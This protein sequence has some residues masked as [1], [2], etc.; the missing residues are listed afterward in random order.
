MLFIYLCKGDLYSDL[1]KGDLY[2]RPAGFPKQY[3]VLQMSHQCQV[4]WAVRSALPIPEL[5]QLSIS[6]VQAVPSGPAYW[7]VSSVGPAVTSMPR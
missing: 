5:S 2:F 7:V 1:W 3:Q 6:S 4:F